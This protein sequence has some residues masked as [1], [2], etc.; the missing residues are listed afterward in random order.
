MNKETEKK[1]EAVSIDG[2]LEKIEKLK[3][4]LQKAK[5]EKKA[6][7]PKEEKDDKDKPAEDASLKE[8][9]VKEESKEEVVE[10]KESEDKCAK[11]KCTKDE[12]PAEMAMDI[13]AIKT[14]ARQEVMDDF[15]AREEARQSVRSV[16]GDV[17]V[18][19][20]DSAEDIYKFA[21]EKAGMNLNEIASYKSAFVGFKSAKGKLAMDASSVGS[22][23]ECF[24]DIRLA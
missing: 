12:K 14:E 4:L 21:C 10:D 6:D 9:E 13:D 17:N 15:K 7:E 23:K 2:L 19:A 11:D 5:G 24:K 1:E 3:T 20:F 22:N 8:E 18:M 16:V